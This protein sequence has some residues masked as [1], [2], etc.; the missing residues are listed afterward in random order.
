MGGKLSRVAWLFPV[1]SGD[2]DVGHIEDDAKPKL[3]PEKDA[4]ASIARHRTPNRLFASL[5]I[6][7]RSRILLRGLGECNNQREECSCQ[8]RPRRDSPRI[9]HDYRTLE[10]TLYNTMES[11]ISKFSKKKGSTKRH[12]ESQGQSTFEVVSRRSESPTLTFR[13]GIPTSTLV[14]PAV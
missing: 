9:R 13:Q 7:C 12:D 6:L 1:L 5:H 10:E 14:L 3:A 2:E 8:S 4:T 11:N